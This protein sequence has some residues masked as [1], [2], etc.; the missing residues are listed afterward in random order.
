MTIAVEE[1]MRGAQTQILTHDRFHRM[2][3][4][5][6]LCKTILLAD[7]VNEEG[8]VVVRGERLAG[9]EIHQ[10]GLHASEEVRQAEDPAPESERISDETHD[11]A[12]RVDARSTPLVGP[13]A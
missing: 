10:Q 13:A 6:E 12:E 3:N 4:D 8:A 9:H 7:A 5:S 2:R 11:L 1:S